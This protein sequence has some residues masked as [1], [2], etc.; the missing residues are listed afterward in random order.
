MAD[1]KASPRRAVGKHITYSYD[2]LI[3]VSINCGKDVALR[4]L[5]KKIQELSLAASLHGSL[6]CDKEAAI[7]VIA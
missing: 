3:A 6:F 5:F 1:A 2:N 4:L 7:H